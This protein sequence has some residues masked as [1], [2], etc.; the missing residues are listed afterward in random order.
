MNFNK[1]FKLK[2]QHAFLS[3]SQY[4]WIR[5]DEKKLIKRYNNSQSSK[6][7]SELHEYA[8]KAIRLGIKQ[9]KSKKTLNAYINDAIGFKMK[10]EQ[11]VYYS[12]NCFGTVDAI[13]FRENFLRIHD[14]KTG[15]SP[16][17]MDQLIIYAG[18][19]CME[20]DIDPQYISIELRI[21]Q[22]DEIVIFLPEPEDIY[23]IIN[24]IK[25]ADKIINK[26]RMEEY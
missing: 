26:C 17:S 18:I 14:L 8:E 5:D 20:Y 12:E 3:A 7:G 16:A 9:A 2:G 10:P 25:R 11:I 24:I 22:N 19:F 1:H 15:V 4:H 23:D 21:Y 13:S 6:R